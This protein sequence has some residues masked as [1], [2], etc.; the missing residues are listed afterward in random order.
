LLTYHQPCGGPAG[1][2]RT[3]AAHLRRQHLPSAE[4]S[5]DLTVPIAQPAA[6]AA[7]W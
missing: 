5:R 6:V 4:C 1:K 3:L 7:S 2:A